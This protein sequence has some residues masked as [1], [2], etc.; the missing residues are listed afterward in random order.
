MWYVAQ[1]DA[2]SAFDKY[3]FQSVSL[4]RNV[5]EG[6]EPAVVERVMENHTF[7]FKTS[8][9][10]ITHSTINTPLQKAYTMWKLGQIISI[11]NSNTNL[12]TSFT[13]TK[14]NTLT[15]TEHYTIYNAFDRVNMHILIRKFTNTNIL[16]SLQNTS[17]KLSK[18]LHI[19]NPN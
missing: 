8:Y 2:C 15:L 11:P 10:D 6:W 13:N 12:W 5:H 1:R 17:H 16:N 9:L 18:T 7:N 19:Y 14:A 3:K 4:L